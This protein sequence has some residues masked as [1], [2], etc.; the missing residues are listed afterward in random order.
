MVQDRDIKW[1]IICAILS[2]LL[3]IFLPVI[4]FHIGI[5]PLFN[6]IWGNI[7]GLGINIMPDI[8]GII[9]S[10]HLWLQLIIMLAW[11][12]FVIC[13][14]VKFALLALRQIDQRIYVYGPMIITLIL[15]LP[16]NLADGLG[17]VFSPAY[18][19]M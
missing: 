8:L 6:I 3:G 16:L 13:L 12:I 18:F 5:S 2:G 11:P 17:L 1:I 14:T 19:G 4:S 9:S 10:H 15:C 7:Y